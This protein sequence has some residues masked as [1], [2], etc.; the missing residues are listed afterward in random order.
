[1]LYDKRNREGQIFEPIVYKNLTI[2]RIDFDKKKLSGSAHGSLWGSFNS[3]QIRV[4]HTH[5]H[6]RKYSKGNELPRQTVPRAPGAESPA[7]RV[8]LAAES[9][10]LLLLLLVY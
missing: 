3:V 2:I 7:L 6:E 1:M 8:T 9:A 4:T 5:T 10:L